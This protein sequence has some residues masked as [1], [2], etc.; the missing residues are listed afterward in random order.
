MSE[1]L[2]TLQSKIA[3]F[4][5]ARDWDQFHGAKDLGIGLV[6]E[7]SELLEIF[8]FQSDQ[9]VA[10]LF[11]GP[12]RSDIED[13]MADVLFFLL[14]MAQRYDVDLSAAL[15]SKMKKNEEKYPVEKAK[16]SNKKYNQFDPS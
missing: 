8:R 5:R 2:I 16:G 13:E 14:R 11:N 6:T 12:R 10:E 9:Q 1:N 15:K 4:C 3:D 7:A